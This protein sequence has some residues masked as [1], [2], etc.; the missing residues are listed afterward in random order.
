MNILT[1]IRNSERRIQKTVKTRDRPL[2]QQNRLIPLNMNFD[3]FHWLKLRSEK[4]VSWYL[5][6]L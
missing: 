1:E 6:I 2:S 3:E 5:C 4:V